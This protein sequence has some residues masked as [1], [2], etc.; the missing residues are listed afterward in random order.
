M[1]RCA[2]LLLLPLSLLPACIPYATTPL[3]D[4]DKAKLDERLCGRWSHTNTD[5]E[6]STWTI[7][8]PKRD[9]APAGLMV[10]VSVWCD[11][12]HEVDFGDACFF[13]TVLGDHSYMNVIKFDDVERMEAR[14][15]D[16]AKVTRYTFVRYRVEG[17]TLTIWLMDDKPVAEAIQAG[18]L[19]GTVE[20]EKKSFGKTVTITDTTDNLIRFVKAEAKALFPDEDRMVLTRIK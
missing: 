17:D 6:T 10:A 1:P 14:K 20:K 5:G 19:K 7:G 4:P 8:K 13:P 16:M 11:K 18:R 3:S 12:N 9:G 2:L 15:W